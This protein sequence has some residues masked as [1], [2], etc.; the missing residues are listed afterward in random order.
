MAQ[1]LSKSSEA[2][3]CEMCFSDPPNSGLISI[4]RQRIEQS[5]LS[6][7]TTRVACAND[8][9]WVVR[10]TKT[11]A[12]SNKINGRREIIQV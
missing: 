3:S 6:K 9:A 10:F 12:M 5:S 1:F 2:W 4:S 7:G 8:G 11:E